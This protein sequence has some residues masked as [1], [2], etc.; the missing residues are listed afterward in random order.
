MLDVVPARIIVVQRRDETV[1]CPND[2]M[3]V[4]ASPPADRRAR[5]AR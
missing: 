4:S 3:I 1:A 2:D 5:K